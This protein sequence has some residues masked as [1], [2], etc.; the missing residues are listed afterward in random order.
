M[1]SKVLFGISCLSSACFGMT[2]DQ[3]EYRVYD[4]EREQRVN[5]YDTDQFLQK[6]DIAKLRKFLDDGGKIRIHKLDNGDSRLTHEVSGKGGGGILAALAVTAT[7]VVGGIATVAT[8]IGVTVVTLNPVAGVAAGAV[9]AKGTCVAAVY[10][11]VVTTVAPT[12]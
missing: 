9:V 5:R 6:I 3:V 11:G 10:V 1:Y 7:L 12:P 8:G 4:G 2:R